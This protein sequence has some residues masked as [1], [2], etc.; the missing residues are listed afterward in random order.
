MYIIFHIFFVQST[1]Y[2]II[3]HI[4]TVTLL[5]TWWWNNYVMFYPK[6]AQVSSSSYYFIVFFPFYFNL[7]LFQFPFY[8]ISFQDVSDENNATIVPTFAAATAVA[9]TD[10]APP[11]CWSCCE[12][13]TNAAKE[14]H[15]QNRYIYPKKNYKPEFLSQTSQNSHYLFVSF[16]S[17]INLFIASSPSFS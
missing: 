11:C 5:E 12:H 17:R 3:F 7:F 10:A 6:M 15:Q 8:S 16:F 2:I 4:S 9:A 13:Q 14:Q 1:I